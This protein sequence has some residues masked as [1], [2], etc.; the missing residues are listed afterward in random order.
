MKSVENVMKVGDTV[1]IS[2]REK[3]RRIHSWSDQGSCK[4]GVSEAEYEILAKEER[5]KKI[6]EVKEKFLNAGADAVILN[7]SELADLL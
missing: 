2:K 3:C 6:N 1:L 5:E 7:L 4:M